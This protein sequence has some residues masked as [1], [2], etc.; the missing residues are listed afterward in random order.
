M[1]SKIPLPTDNVYKFYALFGLVLLVFGLASTLYLTKSTNEFMAT[2][3]VDLEDL[4]SQTVLT[5]RD[6]ARKR[7]LER[8]VEVATKDKELLLSGAA[9]V[10]AIGTLAMCLGFARW[11]FKIQP[12]QD[13][14]AELQLAKLRQ[15][16]GLKD[17]VRPTVRRLGSRRFPRR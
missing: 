12:V 7:L 8:Q 17:G 16:A 9:V 5:P 6:A 10:A 14:V 2:A 13:E 11:Q 4:K 15:E 3:Y 1:D